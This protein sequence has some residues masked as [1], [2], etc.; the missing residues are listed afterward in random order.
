[1]DAPHPEADS[2]FDRKQEIIIAQ[3]AQRFN[4][5]PLTWNPDKIKLGDI[6]NNIESLFLRDVWNQKFLECVGYH[7]AQNAITP[8]TEEQ[9]KSLTEFSKKMA[10]LIA[11]GFHM[12]EQL[13]ENLSFADGNEAK[14]LVRIYMC[15]IIIETITHLQ[16]LNFPDRSTLSILGAIRKVAVQTHNWLGGNE[17]YTGLEPKFVAGGHPEK[18]AREYLQKAAEYKQSLQREIDSIDTQRKSAEKLR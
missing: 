5:A 16:S 8:L 7:D 1:M 15:N 3:I 9:K 11:R 13:V 4:D 6:E 12:R 17:D 18:A 14:C 10:G 2:P